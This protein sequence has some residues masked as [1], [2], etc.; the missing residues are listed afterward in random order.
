[1][2]LNMIRAQHSRSIERNFFLKII[3]FYCVHFLTD[4]FD[5]K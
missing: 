3:S 2:R 4:V 5:A 1:M